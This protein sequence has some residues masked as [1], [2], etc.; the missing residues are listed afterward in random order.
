MSPKEI[1]HLR[2]INQQ[3]ILT[4]MKNPKNVVSW[5]GAMQAQDY[6]MVRWA[7]ASRLDGAEQT[8]VQRAMDSGK[9]VRTH[10]LR[11]TWHLAAVE[12]VGWMTDLSAPQTRT[13]A[14]PRLRELGLT[15]AI[16]KKSL[17]TFEREL[18]GGKHFTREEMLASLERR[19]ITTKEQRGPY[20][21]MWAE[22]EKVICSGPIVGTKN[23]YALYSER[24]KKQRSL[25]GEEALAELARRYLTSRGP[26]TLAD[27]TNWS[28]LSA[29]DARRAIQSVHDEFEEF[30]ADSTKYWFRGKVQ[31]APQEPVVHLLPAFDE[32]I[33]GYKDRSAALAAN[34][35][36][37]VISINGIFW[38]IIVVNGMVTGL[39][40]RIVSKGT[41][42]VELQYFPGLRMRNDPEIKR[43]TAQAVKQVEKF[44]SVPDVKPS[45]R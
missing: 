21:L 10:L 15:P 42:S 1:C 2:L 16:L 40:K 43:L 22:L 8:T 3:L 41:A 4:R 39:W 36:T 35:R 14:K 33:I 12:D 25:A 5:M 19:K 9:I 24:V 44:F 29:K 38:P 27:F 13:I 7:V 6:N 23:S 11:P 32:Y 34:H 26:A 30:E 31:T 45:K 28:G 20:I 18:E 37:K 17:E